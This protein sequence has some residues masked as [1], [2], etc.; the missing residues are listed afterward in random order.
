GHGGSGKSTLALQIAVAVAM[1]LPLLGRTTTKGPVL[2]FS[3]EDAAPM[4][5]H[6][7]AGICKALDVNPRALAKSLLALDATAE[8]EL[9]RELAEYGHS[10]EP[11]PV[12]HR[13]AETLTEWQPVLAV[14]DNASDTFCGNENNRAQVRTF[15]RALAKLARET[16]STP[17]MLLLTHT[18]KSAVGGRGESYSGSTSWHNS[19]RARLSLTPDK[20]D[21]SRVILSLD[22][23]NL[24]PM[25]TEPLRLVRSHGGV[26]VLD[27]DS[28]R[29]EGESGSLEG[30]KM[31][32]IAI[33]ELLADYT[34]RGEWVATSPNSPRVNAWALFHQE[35][36]FPKRAYRNAAA[37]FAAMRELSRQGLI[38]RET[39]RTENR[40][41]R[42][43]W[44]LTEAGLER[45]GKS[46]P[47]APSAPSE[48]V[49]TPSTPS[50]VDA[51]AGAP[52]APSSAQE[53]MRG[54]R[55]HTVG[56]PDTQN[57][58]RFRSLPLVGSRKDGTNPR[59]LGTNPRALGTNPRA[60]GTNP[61]AVKR[62]A[63][64]G[65]ETREGCE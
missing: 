30:F 54:E 36:N 46:A 25:T 9:Y 8:P 47:S 44:V 52:G 26:L 60:K 32:E 50:A 57:P 11:T 40:K 16:E 62:R 39:V 19:A 56:A 45:I 29:Q 22:K 31:P 63:A 17:A 51:D 24:A 33:L 43:I 48:E 4:L 28:S 38:R 12:F 20:D 18:P 59:A 1:G 14:I 55:A 42:E 27:E 6:R 21:A 65:K 61:R 37:L 2:L 49:S 64:K 7:L 23:M 5:R 58:P 53:S 35:P 10:V 41:Y 15:V 34:E 3:G 13:L